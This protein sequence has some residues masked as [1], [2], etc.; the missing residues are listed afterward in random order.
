MAKEDVLLLETNDRM[1]GF[2]VYDEC[3]SPSSGSCF[4]IEL[5]TVGETIRVY[6]VP[7]FSYDELEARTRVLYDQCLKDLRNLARGIEVG[8]GAKASK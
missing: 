4:D 5:K 2:L 8:W 6:I 1:L 3:R 7:R